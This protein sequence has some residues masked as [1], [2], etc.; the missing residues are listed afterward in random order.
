MIGMTP[1]WQKEGEMDM[2][3]GEILGYISMIVSLSMIFLWR[4]KFRDKHQEGFIT[5]GK[6]FK[7]GFL[8]TLV[9][10]AFYVA[11][12]MIYY[13]TSAS[14]QDFPEQYLEYM[15]TQMEEDGASAE[16]VAEA[17]DTYSSQMELYKNPFVMMGVTLMEILPVG[18]LI[19][20]F[21]AFILKR[22]E[23]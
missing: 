1:L 13:N 14:A 4:E 5:F 19:S 3:M 9:A 6:A 7:V 20:L 17:R 16:E 11:G 15:L 8:I 10:S 18:L 2:Q 23:G 22:K 21:T 12:W